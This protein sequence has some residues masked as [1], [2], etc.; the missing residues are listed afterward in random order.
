MNDNMNLRKNYIHS[1]TKNAAIALNMAQQ[2]ND[3]E[4]ISHSDAVQELVCLIN[5]ASLALQ[6]VCTSMEYNYNDK[7]G[8]RK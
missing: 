1:A 5:S 7:L 2:V 3:K 6:R 4:G 8:K